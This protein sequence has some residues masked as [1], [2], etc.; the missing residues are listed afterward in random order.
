MIDAFNQGVRGEPKLQEHLEAEIDGLIRLK[1]ATFTWGTAA[2]S[3]S[4]DFRLH[5]PDVTF[6]KGKTNLITGSTGSGKSS[7]L[8]A[9][10]GELHFVRKAGSFFHLPREGGVSYV[11]QASWCM[12][13]TIKEN[14]LFG[15]PFEADRYKQVIHDCGLETDLRL[16]DD[17]DATEIG[18]RGVTLSGGQRARITLARAVYCRTDIVLLDGEFRA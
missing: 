5:V 9:L 16:F 3:D 17:G 12:S 10:T 4:T 13:E 7:L 6:V 15:E 11:D 1:N 8:K 2:D 14:I 18:E